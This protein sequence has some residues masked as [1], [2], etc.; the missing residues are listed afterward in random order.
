ME[1]AAPEAVVRLA[2]LYPKLQ[3]TLTADEIEISGPVDDEAVVRRDVA[4]ALYRQRIFQR[5]LPL[6]Q[7]LLD[8]LRTP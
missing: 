3:F 2:Y 7:A 1:E 5:S 4:Y 8:T 6:R